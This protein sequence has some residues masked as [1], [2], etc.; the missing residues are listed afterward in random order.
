MKKK[1]VNKIAE[2][3]TLI[4]E[5]VNSLREEIER[6]KVCISKLK[7]QNEQ[8]KCCGNCKH[9]YEAEGICCNLFDG[10]KYYPTLEKRN[11]E[12]WEE[13][14]NGLNGDQRKIKKRQKL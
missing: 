5:E 12:M 6:Q 1:E 7:T 2:G 8:L 11:C 3:F 10:E 14:K 13:R 4:S 9:C